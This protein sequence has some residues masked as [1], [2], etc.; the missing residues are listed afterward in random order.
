MSSITILIKPSS[1]ACNLD[2]MYC[3][4]K[5][6][7]KNRDNYNNGFMNLDTLE[8][9][10]KYVLN[11]NIKNVTFMFQGGEPTLIGIDFYKKSIEFQEKYNINNIIIT[12]SIQTNGVNIKEDLVHF[13]SDNNFLVGV[14]LD[15]PKY[16]HDAYRFDYNHAG[17]Y[18]EVM[19]FISL[20]KKYNINF[21]ILCVVT[22]LSSKHIHNIYSFYK[23]HKFNYLQFIP[24]IRKF[25]LDIDIDNYY[26]NNETYLEFLDTLFSLWI[27]DLKEGNYIEIRNFMDYITVLKGNHPTSCGMGGFCS[28]H[29]VIESNGDVYPC[30]FYCVDKWKLGN[31]NSSPLNSIRNNHK[32]RDFFNRS[33]YL[34]KECKNCKVFKLC[35]GG[36]RRDL[37]PYIDG[38]PSFNYKCGAIKSFLER[39]LDVLFQ[40]S[41]FL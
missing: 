23:E 29:T 38:I 41:K 35:G 15:G 13:F 1:S 10:I 24:C 17:S 19:N 3:F 25:D 21:N 40:V 4:Y 18:D 9:I 33:L 27:E 36:C 26:L 14:S 28:L 37:E 22:K 16:I 7:S 32:A 30:D 12:N 8:N 11:S 34:H 6:V 39:N 20:L 5:D 2:C 31:I